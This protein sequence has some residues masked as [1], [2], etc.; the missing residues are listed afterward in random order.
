MP[1]VFEVS[2]L[3]RSVRD[4]IES[5]FPFVWVRGQVVNLSRPGSGHMYFSLRDADASLAVVWFKGA[6]GG[7]AL[8]GG[9]RYDPLTGEVYEQSLAETLAD[10]MEVMVAGRLTVYAPRG[11]YQ[12]VAELVQEVG[13]GRLWQ[14]FEALKKDLAAKG[15]FDQERKRSLPRHP[16]RVAVVTAPTGAA[17]RDFIR[18]GRERG[19]GAAVRVYPTLV[20]GDAAPVGIVRAMLRAVAD[21]WAEVVVL[22]RGGGSLEDLWAFNT[23]EVAKAIFASPLPVLTGV[24]HEVDVTIAD[25]VADVRA[26]TPSHAAQLLWPERVQLA[27]RLDD[28]EMGLRRG[29]ARLLALRERDLAS[30]ARGLSWLSPA[31]RLQRLEER[32]AAAGERLSRAGEAWLDALGGRVGKLCDRLGLRFGPQGLE[33]REQG[34][35]RRVEALESAMK[36]FVAERGHR[37]ELAAARFSGLDPEAP[38][39]RGYSLTTL[40]RT[41]KFLRRAGDAR[42]GDKLDIMVY[43][44]RVRAAVEA[45]APDGGASGEGSKERP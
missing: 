37:L 26:A 3:T 11:S 2:E 16:T 34:L 30:L 24:G 15:Y 14:E 43:E 20:Q 35:S 25:M 10:G 38:L 22:I 7:K 45:V 8:A 36:L 21:D 6:Q 32:F 4:V 41:G 31:N 19:Y 9:G 42:P 28:L 39:A 17:V 40:V 27:Q 13:E 12:L 5:E 23:I 29:A 1:H 44:G 33:A 18:I